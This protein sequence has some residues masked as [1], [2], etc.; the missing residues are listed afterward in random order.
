MKG[1]YG[2]AVNIYTQILMRPIGGE[3]N[4]LYVQ[5]QISRCFDYVAMLS[6]LS[7]GSLPDLEERVCRFAAE[8][9][10]DVKYT[11]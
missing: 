7:R 5:M 3:I 8:S 6:S 4:L 10:R 9:R 1:N 2:R 11:E